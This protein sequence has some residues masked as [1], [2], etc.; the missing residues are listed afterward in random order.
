[1]KVI[2]GI[3]NNHYSLAKLLCKHVLCVPQLVHLHPVYCSGFDMSL[4]VHAYYIDS[5][6]N[7][8]CKNVSTS[9]GSLFHYVV[10]IQITFKTG[11]DVQQK[12]VLQGAGIC[13][14]IISA[15]QRSISATNVLKI[16]LIV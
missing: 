14:V 9:T 16:N 2:E 3:A 4:S 15:Q 5:I 11:M 13:F 7:N 10:E 1:M 8:C 12:L 6:S